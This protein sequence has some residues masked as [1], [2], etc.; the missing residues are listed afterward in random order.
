MVQTRVVVFVLHELLFRHRERP[1]IA[2]RR[3]PHA[4]Q[5]ETI[6]QEVDE[7]RQLLPVSF[8]EDRLVEEIPDRGFDARG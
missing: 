8:A 2:L 1:L 6:D 5:V 3:R 7:R 4:Y